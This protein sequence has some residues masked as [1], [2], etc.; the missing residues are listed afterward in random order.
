MENNNHMTERS[1]KLPTSLSH[2][3]QLELLKDSIDL[4]FSSPEINEFAPMKGANTPY[5]PRSYQSNKNEH[6]RLPIFAAEM[7]FNDAQEYDNFKRQLRYICSGVILLGLFTPFINIVSATETFTGIQLMAGLGQAFGLN[8][9]PAALV[10]GVAIFPI[11]LCLYAAVIA[12]NPIALVFNENL[13]NQLW[14]V[15]ATSGILY[16]FAAFMFIN[17][18]GQTTQ[19]I[20]NTIGFGYYVTM[21][22]IFT[23]HFLTQWADQNVV[24]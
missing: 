15:T 7:T 21:I 18:E 14:S 12:I 4:R 2:E 24:T 19:T 17:L 22:T 20:T 1:A 3:D 6:E 5:M 8:L 16:F 13:L 9:L 23:Y 11:M 10:I